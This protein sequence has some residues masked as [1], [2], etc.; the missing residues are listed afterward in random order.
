VGAEI[1]SEIL[2]Q[3][4]A[5]SD[6]HKDKP[7]PIFRIKYDVQF[8]LAARPGG[9]AGDAAIHV[10][11]NAEAFIKVPQIKWCTK[12]VLGVKVRYPC[13]VTLGWGSLGTL[14]GEINVWPILNG[15]TICIARDT[16][17]FDSHFTLLGD[18]LALL[19]G[20]ALALVIPG[21]QVFGL[22]LLLVGNLLD[23]ILDLL[24]AAVV[25]SALCTNIQKFLSVP[26]VKDRVDLSLTTNTA[27]EFK[28]TGLSIAV[29][30]DFHSV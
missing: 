2:R 8:N 20:E 24:V 27:L 15:T 18:I 9:A 11:G 25:P 10:V 7:G 23:K 21:G 19:V 26:V 12:T 14:H 1:I 6:Y 28:T 16:P 4:S 30:G 22:V 13:G 3:L 29:D 5:K 17:I